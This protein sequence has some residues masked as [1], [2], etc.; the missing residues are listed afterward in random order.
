MENAELLPNKDRVFMISEMVSSM[1]SSGIR[2]TRAKPSLTFLTSVSR[3]SHT[4]ATRAFESGKYVYIDTYY[5][6]LVW[7]LT[8]TFSETIATPIYSGGL[9][10]ASLY[11][12][13]KL[14]GTNADRVDHPVQWLT[15]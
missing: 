4:E 14:K 7:D 13:L 1:N 12:L 6:T 15:T 9:D 11:A 10:N 2:L 3:S 5:L 8:P